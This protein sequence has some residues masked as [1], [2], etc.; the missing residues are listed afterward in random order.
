[1]VASTYYDRADTRTEALDAGNAPSHHN[2]GGQAGGCGGRDGLDCGASGEARC[3]PPCAQQ[4]C[5]R[6]PVRCHEYMCG[7]FGH[8]TGA[9]SLAAPAQPY[10]CSAWPIST[11]AHTGA[12]MQAQL[13]GCA[14]IYT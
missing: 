13:G 6:C 2:L 7:S 11:T 8:Q 9:W 3:R 1:M 4:A 12:R 10:F 5:S 14:P